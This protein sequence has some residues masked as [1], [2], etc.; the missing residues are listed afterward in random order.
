MSKP[1]GHSESCRQGAICTCAILLLAIRGAF[2]P[3]SLPA[4]N[5]VCF[6]CRLT[7]NAQTSSP[8][9]IEMTLPLEMAASHFFAWDKPITLKV[10]CPAIILSKLPPALTGISFR[11]GLFS[12][13]VDGSGTLRNPSLTGT[14]SCLNGRFAK[15][16]GPVS[17]IGGQIDFR[18][19]L[20]AITVANLEFD[21]ARLSL[22]GAID[23]T[24]TSAIS[25]KLIP[26]TALFELTVIPP[27]KC[28]GGVQAFASRRIDP[29]TSAFTEIQEMELKGGLH[30][31][32]WSVSLTTSDEAKP[33]ENHSLCAS[34]GDTLQLTIASTQKTEIGQRAL[35]IFR[36]HNSPG[37]LKQLPRP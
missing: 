10:D 8:A 3:I 2:P 22:H 31:N 21:D 27:G 11:D 24:D 7:A 26:D 15:L 37:S 18:G 16:P 36:G 9:K 29:N 19:S 23:F 25:I 14:V 33:R 4:F 5:R 6:E 20:A 30:S 34:G 13:N 35:R 17:G 32:P 1:S 28:I 12:A